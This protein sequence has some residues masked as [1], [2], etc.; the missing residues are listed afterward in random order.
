MTPAEVAS[1]QLFLESSRKLADRLLDEYVPSSEVE[2]KSLHSAMRYSV[3]AGG[4]RIR[5]ALALSAWEY[6]Q[7]DPTRAAATIH[8]AMASLEL[9][10]TY[11]LI[12]DDLPCMDD[13]D[14]RRGIPTCHKKF[15][16]AL[17]VL[18]GDA[19]HVIS[20]QLMA[21]TGCLE[22]VTELAQAVGTS[23]MLGGQVADIEA[24]GR[25]TNC[26]EVIGIHR[27]KTGALILSSVRIG[28]MLA[29]APPEKLARLSSYGQNVGLA[30]QIIDDILDIE[31][32]QKTLGKK[33]GADSKK[34]KATFPGAVGLKKAREEAGRLIDNALA[35]FDEVEENSLKDIAR[36]IGQREN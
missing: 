33:V 28:A 24:E 3:M 19:L 21:Q 22:A 11:S 15:G 2:P 25:E 31:G 34:L 10:H 26:D 7:G 5:P 20:F 23:G 29:G 32:D 14:L 13:D 9:I 18:A 1:A 35:V 36:F 16:E 27:R 30:F 12:H 4:K 8:P 17:A 6:C